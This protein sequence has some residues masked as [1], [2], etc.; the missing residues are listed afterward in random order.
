MPFFKG[1][2]TIPLVGGENLAKNYLQSKYCKRLSFHPLGECL[3]PTGRPY[4][5]PGQN[6]KIPP[7]SPICLHFNFLQ[8]TYRS[9]LESNPTEL[10]RMIL[11]PP[12]SV[13]VWTRLP[14]PCLISG[15]MSDHHGL[16]FL[17]V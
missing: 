10:F 13:L 3:L 12:I 11:L 5:P 17:M 9:R 15:C 1:G 14:R 6:L 8:A 16:T 7:V 4:K 2:R